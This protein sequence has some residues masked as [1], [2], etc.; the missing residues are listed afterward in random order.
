VLSHA[1]ESA[2]KSEGSSFDDDP[3]M[4]PC[5]RAA[6]GLLEEAVKRKHSSEVSIETVRALADL[7]IHAA[8]DERAWEEYIAHDGTQGMDPLTT[9]LNWQWPIRLRG[10]THLMAWRGDAPWFDAARGAL[11]RELDRDDAWGASR[12]VIGESVGRLMDAVPDWTAS[13]APDLFGAGESLSVAQQIALTTATSVYRYHPALY[14][15]LTPAM[16]AAIKAGEPIAAGWRT[17]TDPLQAIGEWAIE[18]IIRGNSTID[19]PVAHAFF[20]AAPAQVRGAALGHTG[21]TFMHASAVDDPIRDQLA[22]LWDERVAQVRS[23]PGSE[24]EVSGFYWFV[25]SGKF[26]IEWW[27]PRL[28]EALELYPTLA[29]ERF[30]IGK[31][32]ALA[33]DVDPRAALDVLKLLLEASDQNGLAGYDL[34]R[35]AVPVVLGRAIASGDDDLMD[36]AVRYMNKLG[37][38]GH[39]GLAAEVQAVIDGA[40]TQADVDG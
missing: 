4:R 8:D 39:L 30:L 1:D 16:V 11:E 18:S 5:K 32:V 37:E 22:S 14:E 38:A 26:S 40:I 20:S 12:A 25:R 23:H 34:T 19:H 7:L 36:E 28:R 31:E 33:A 9:S 2:I 24:A 10:L 15:L 27:L 29:A 17:Q 3:D 13:K 6:V 35:N 21:W